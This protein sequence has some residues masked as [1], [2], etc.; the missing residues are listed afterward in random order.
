MY[1]G[2]FTNHPTSSFHRFMKTWTAVRPR[3]ADSTGEM[4]RGIFTRYFFL[5]GDI[6]LVGSNIP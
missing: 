1:Q 6:F 3:Q 2:P 4:R 5:G